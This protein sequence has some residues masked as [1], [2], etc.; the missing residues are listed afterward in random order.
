M[1]SDNILI[2]ITPQKK[3]DWKKAAKKRGV[4]LT[5][6]IEDAVYEYLK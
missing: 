5:R 6:L 3:E 4:D 2:R 1:K